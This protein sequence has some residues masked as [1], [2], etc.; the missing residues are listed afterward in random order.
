[1]TTS[2]DIKSVMRE[3]YQLAEKTHGPGGA[4]GIVKDGEIVLQHTWGYAD[5]S[6]A[7]R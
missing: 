6:R 5:S 4:I 1:M 2:I 7:A 3:A